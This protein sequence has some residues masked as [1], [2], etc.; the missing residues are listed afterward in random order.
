MPSIKNLFVI[1]ARDISTD[2]RDQMTS[3]MKIV[4]RFG[5]G[6]DPDQMKDQGVTLGEK[7][8]VFPAKYDVATSW[9]LGEHLKTD[10]LLTFTLSVRDP[11]GR[12]LGGPSQ[13]H[14]LP[15]GVDRANMNFGMEG[16][17]V[18]EP[19]KYTLEVRILSKDGKELSSGEYPFLVDIQKE[20]KPNQAPAK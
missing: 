20:K 16:L 7:P 2:A 10:T 5:F 1:I 9:Y 12:D 11:K 17:P 6:Y 8:V 3:I 4:E 18:T 13:E 14:M 19:G 15:A